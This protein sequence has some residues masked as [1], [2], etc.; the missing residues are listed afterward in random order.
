[1]Q[2]LIIRILVQLLKIL[3]YIKHQQ[4]EPPVAEIA[5]LVV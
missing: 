3:T 4:V 1:M 2:A 5:E